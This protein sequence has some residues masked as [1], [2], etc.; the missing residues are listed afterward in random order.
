VNDYWRKAVEAAID[1]RLLMDAGRADGATSR[2][3]YA[4]FDAARA[5]LEE[6][7][8]DL[9]LAK[10]HSAIINRFSQH[11]VIDKHLDPN[12]GR[13]LNTA[14]SLKITA[15]YDRAA[16]S[17]D[18]AKSAVERMNQFLAVV[19]GLIGEQPP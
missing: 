12:I 14:E 1:A 17:L 11:V 5:A 16:V 13:Y 10:T 18:E 4:R 3:Y 9:T 2:A 7:R 15:D 6:V 8:P 19:A